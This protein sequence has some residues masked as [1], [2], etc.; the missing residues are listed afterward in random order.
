MKQ[1]KISEQQD[2]EIRNLIKENI[3]NVNA[4]A[5][6]DG[7][8]VEPVVSTNEPVK[9][10]QAIPVLTQLDQKV[11]TPLGI[12]NTQVKV[13]NT[14]TELPK[15]VS[16]TTPDSAGEVQ[17]E[18]FIITM[19]QLNEMRLKKLKENSQKVKVKDFLK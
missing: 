2:K 1:I 10:Q 3:L 4:G 7:K 5:G 14:P 13:K 6:V 11:A 17:N 9:P 15:T 18:S 8:E 19:K 12:D 16:M